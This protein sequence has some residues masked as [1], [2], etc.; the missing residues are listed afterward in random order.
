VQPKEQ[1]VEVKEVVSKVADPDA[2]KW[3]QKAEGEAWEAK[4]KVKELQ[5]KLKELGD[6][7]D[8]LK[9]LE[10]EKADRE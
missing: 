3:R 7:E 1:V 8:K 6:L 5:A 10:A 4:R 9:E 2:D